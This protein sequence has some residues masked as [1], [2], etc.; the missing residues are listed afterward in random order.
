MLN[1]WWL[2]TPS[3][4]DDYFV[5]SRRHFHTFWESMCA[6]LGGASIA[7]L[8][9]VVYY[10]LGVVSSLVARGAALHGRRDGFR[11]KVDDHGSR[12]KFFNLCGE[13]VLHVL[14]ERMG[15]GCIGQ[16]T[17][18]KHAWNLPGDRMIP[19]WRSIPFP[20]EQARASR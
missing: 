20:K 12:T 6:G 4:C 9:H 8:L 18:I 19:P 11:W 2:K 14:L 15:T 10:R 1:L 5:P 3:I 13:T 16:I 7:Q 17:G